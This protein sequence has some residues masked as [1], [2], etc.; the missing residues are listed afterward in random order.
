M[1]RTIGMKQSRSHI[2]TVNRRTNQQLNDTSPDRIDKTS[3]KGNLF[4]QNKETLEMMLIRKLR[5]KY[6]ETNSVF[7]TSL[8]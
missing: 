2:A 8:L 5:M 7:A 4:K 3:P 6:I 1:S